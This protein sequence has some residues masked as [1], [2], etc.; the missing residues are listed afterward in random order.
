M[1]KNSQPPAI[2]AEVAVID[3]PIIAFVGAYS[4]GK[5]FLINYLTRTD[6]LSSQIDPTTAV[7]TVLRHISDRPSTWKSDTVFALK[8]GSD[9]RTLDPGSIEESGSYEDL[10]R[11]TTY[12][13]TEEP[14]S[15][16]YDVVVVFLESEYLSDKIILDCPGVGVLSELSE[17]SDAKANLRE[18]RLQ[19]RAMQCSDG[20]VVLSAV[21]GNAGVFGDNNTRNVLVELSCHAQRFPA[22]APHANILLVA[23]HADPRKK[24]LQ[25]QEAVLQK[26]RHKIFEQCVNLP[27]KMR[28][29]LD[30]EAL[31]G[32]V[33]LFYKLDSNETETRIA[34]IMKTLKRT[35]ASLSSAEMKRI[36]EEQFA[37]DRGDSERFEALDAALQ[38]MI[39]GMKLRMDDYRLQHSIQRVE[40]SIAHF[41]DRQLKAE[42]K[43]I[44]CE[45]MHGQSKKYHDEHSAREAAWI[46]LGSETSKRCK[47]ASGATIKDFDAFYFKFSDVDYVENFIRDNYK[48]DQKE[49]ATLYLTGMIERELSDRLQSSILKHIDDVETATRQDLE[50]FDKTFLKRKDCEILPAHL[51]ERINAL[52]GPPVGLRLETFSALGTFSAIT[53]GIAGST[54]LAAGL[55][56][57]LAQ[58][59][60]A[61]VLLISI[62]AA[63]VLGLGGAA[64]GLA[65]GI[66]L[67]GW[68]IVGAAALAAAWRFFGRSW[69]KQM[70]I[71]VSKSI[72]DNKI[73]ASRGVRQAV[74]TT[75]GA[76]E[77][78]LAKTL[79]ATKISIDAHVA[80]VHAMAA[81]E[82]SAADVRSAAEFYR[83]HLRVL[84]ETLESLRA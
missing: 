9:P 6:F 68:A 57:A 48:D 79:E 38:V 43:A 39:N 29:K 23:S 37:E 71:T 60:L 56:S 52:S 19:K 69:Q 76:A 1:D 7:I 28:E 17:E 58:A 73:V 63:G 62:G 44:L 41:E 77:E 10:T 67:I 16:P 12:A 14:S 51:L 24:D 33:V 53:A 34:E 31:S 27:R 18:M 66:P 35:N 11:L 3:K 13:P 74:T 55:G 50:I 61:K 70:A 20:F 46:T 49:Q 8:P 65:A 59:V 83:C 30:P 2:Y 32:R 45:E 26:V 5:T 21:S 15:V 72:R 22:A 40:R 25:K 4:S 82:V 47:A 84:S 81:G 75:M 78:T 80:E 42:I 64:T 54:M 36:A